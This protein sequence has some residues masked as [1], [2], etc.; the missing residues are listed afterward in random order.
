MELHRIDCLSSHRDL[1]LYDFVSDKLQS[2]PL[3]QMRPTALITG[4]DLIGI[5]YMP[6]PRFKE[7]LSAVEDAQLDGKLQSREDAL[8]LVQKEFPR[9]N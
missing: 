6:G 1:S 2:T 8:E 7:I 9:P 3:E 5:G 4:T